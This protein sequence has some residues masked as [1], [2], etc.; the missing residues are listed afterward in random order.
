MAGA[1]GN[2]TG[3]PGAGA[4]GARGGG[5]GG[6]ALGVTAGAPGTT[7]PMPPLLSADSHVVEPGDLWLERL[8]AR[9]RDTAPR[10]IKDPGN[11][12]WYFH[13][14][15]QPRGVDLTLSVTAGLTRAEVDALLAQ[16]PDAVPGA[17]GG[18]D[19]VSRLGDLWRDGVLADVL[20]PTAGLS[21][22]G[23][24][25]TA[26]AGECFEVYNRWLADFCAVDPRR[27]LG[28]ALVPCADVAR[29]VRVL[30]E[31]KAAGLAGGL[32]WTAPPLGDSFFDPRYEPLWAAAEALGMPLAVHTLGGQ[33]ESR[34]V[35]RLGT[36]VPS[37][38]HVA[39]DYRQ[40]LQRSVCELVAAGV[41]QRHPGLQVVGAEA[42]IHFVAEMERRM[43]SGYKGFWAKLPD[44]TLAE[45]PSYYFRRNV[46]WTYI[47]D[48]VGLT[49]LG[50]TG[51]D[52]LMWSSD[53]PHGAS[54][55]PRSREV[56]A[57]DHAGVAPEALRA[58]VGGNCA[59]LYG[60]DVDAVASPSPAVAVTV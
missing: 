39:I 12:H 25:D 29:G 43:D 23:L 15:G 55:Y 4:G 60:I 33:R 48:P 19:P 56:V 3:G 40:E 20:Y 52:R 57:T 31:A 35:R 58:L 36:D 10:A 54:T 37:S 7:T 14:P 21:L 28:L 45:P 24:E 34:E 59:A 8:P 27:L 17:K 51:T 18:S 22:L 41:F 16:D 13:V 2:G 49:L 11:H 9:R 32:I 26:L 6:G 5:A 50:F 30:E 46:W 1:S 38:Y 47:S 53:Y 44:C 42:G